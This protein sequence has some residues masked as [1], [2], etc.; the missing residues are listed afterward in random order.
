[1]VA[2][3]QTYGTAGGFVG[4]IRVRAKMSYRQ[5][6]ALDN[7]PVFNSITTIRQNPDGRVYRERVGLEEEKEEEKP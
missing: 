3:V 7:D 1:M 5:R 2:G 6:A 4:A